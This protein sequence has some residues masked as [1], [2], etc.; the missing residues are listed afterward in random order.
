MTLVIE[1]YDDQTRETTLRVSQTAETINIFV[2]MV[3]L[4]RSSPLQKWS[5]VC[6][7]YK[8]YILLT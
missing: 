6:H 2:A 3:K 4:S 5:P 7:I 1:I 8:Q